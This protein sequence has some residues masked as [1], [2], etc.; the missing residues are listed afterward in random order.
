MSWLFTVTLVQLTILKVYPA[1]CPEAKSP[2][3]TCAAWR[4]GADRN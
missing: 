3:R 1:F 2:R 4:A